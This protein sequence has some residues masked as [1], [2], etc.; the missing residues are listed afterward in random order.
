MNMQLAALLLR[1]L[2]AA[3]HP[4]ISK[5]P[6][7]V[8]GVRNSDMPSG[9]L[10]SRLRPITAGLSTGEAGRIRHS[11]LQSPIL[12]GKTSA[13]TLRLFLTPL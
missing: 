7:K 6:P 3:N 9:N 8:F 2:P 4:D 10:S 1:A 12:I 5:F 11:E 13:Q